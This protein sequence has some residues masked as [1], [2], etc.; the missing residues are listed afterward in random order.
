[1]TDPNGKLMLSSEK[2]GS[3]AFISDVHRSISPV[4]CLSRLRDALNDA[5]EIPP[6]ER[7]VWLAQNVADDEE[8][9]AI[10]TLLLAFDGDGF[11]DADVG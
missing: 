8:R 3:G 11:I 9:E 5:A 2:N 6:E 10:A 7:D 4:D 1:M